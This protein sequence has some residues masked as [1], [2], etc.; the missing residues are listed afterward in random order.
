MGKINLFKKKRKPCIVCSAK[1]WRE[2]YESAGLCKKCGKEL[3]KIWEERNLSTYEDSK[4]LVNELKIK[5]KA[6][7]SI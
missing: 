5:C 2:K 3:D 7:M 4:N 6:R 1:V